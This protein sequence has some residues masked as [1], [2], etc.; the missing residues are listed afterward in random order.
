MNTLEIRM[1]IQDAH[2]FHEPGDSVLDAVRKFHYYMYRQI[3]L[4]NY[5]AVSGTNGLSYVKS[6]YA[7]Y[8]ERVCA[9]SPEKLKS[10]QDNLRLM[11]NASNN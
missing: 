5:I 1:T 10:I 7:S 4:G 8:V 3:E 6:E 9:L 2:H 11:L